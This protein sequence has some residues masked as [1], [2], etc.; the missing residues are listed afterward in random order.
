MR[1]NRIASLV[2]GAAFGALGVTGLIVALASHAGPAGV[3]L[4]DTASTSVPLALVHLAIA[5]VLLVGFLRPRMTRSANV[6]VG[7]ALLLLGMLGLFSVGTEANVLALNGADNL[8]HFA[9]STALLATGLGAPPRS[10]R[11]TG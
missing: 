5:V 3:L 4:L 8:L 2:T 6:A 7:T 9:A 1:A 11:T 10:E